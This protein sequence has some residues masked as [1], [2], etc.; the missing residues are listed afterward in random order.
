MVEYRTSPPVTQEDLRSIGFP[1]TLGH[2]LGHIC[3][4]L[5]ERIVGC[6]NVA[7]DGG[8]HAFLLDPTVHEE[9][10][11]KGIGTEMIRRA[12]DLARFRGV[13]WLHVDFEP[14]L[15]EFYEGCGFRKSPA[16]VMKLKED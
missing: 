16:G 6:V 2:G 5:G 13:E 10:R 11:R 15:W 12:R 4:F 1:G 14:H 7:W 8:A 3:A 9:Y